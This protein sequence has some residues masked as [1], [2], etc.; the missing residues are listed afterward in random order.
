MSFD[1]FKSQPQCVAGK[2]WNECGSPCERTCANPVPVCAAV[3]MPQCECPLSAPLVQDGVCVAAVQCS[4]EQETLQPG[5]PHSIPVGEFEPLA[6][7]ALGTGGKVYRLAHFALQE[8]QK[9]SCK[10]GTVVC[11]AMLSASLIRIKSA[12][13]QVVSGVNYQIE[14]VTSRGLLVVSLYEQAWTRTLVLTS[15]SLGSESLIATELLLDWEAMQASRGSVAADVASSSGDIT[16]SL[17]PPVK[18]LSAERQSPLQTNGW[19]IFLIAVSLMLVSL[20]LAYL[21]KYLLLRICFGKA[22]EAPLTSVMAD[23]SAMR[24]VSE[25]HLRVDGE[26]DRL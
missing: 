16:L 24:G 17:V 8:L 11:D 21:L 12:S 22:E 26:E 9:I 1:A 3:C 6:D 4:A 18:A 13:T 2:M 23:A 10:A 7:S 14:C 5:Q 20:M 25:M 15:A 19:G